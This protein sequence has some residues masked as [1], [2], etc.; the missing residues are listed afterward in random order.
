MPSDLTLWLLHGLDTAQGNLSFMAWNSFLALVPLALSFWLF[1]RGGSHARPIFWWVG[2]VVFV[3]FLP[4]A[5]YVLTDI[6]HLVKDIRSGQSVWAVALILVPQYF[7]FIGLGIFAYTLAI[8]N[9]G[10]YLS[11]LG[12]IRW[13]LPT[14]L[15][16]HGLSAIGIYLG[17]FLRFNSWDLVT[18]P[19]TVIGKTLG[20]LLVK[21]SLIV[22][23]GTFLIIAVVH[24]LLKQI[25][26][27][28]I[29]YW[30]TRH[31]RAAQR[32]LGGGI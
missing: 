11:R 16:L 1:R 18:R 10:R 22:M 21:K 13:V 23:V 24:W 6:I 31:L 5:P 27:A 28:M 7:V 32:H 14:E 19:G 8:V 2:L 17:R 15:T 20:L 26:L 4:N 9:L 30:R 12:K 3:A 29:F 25:T